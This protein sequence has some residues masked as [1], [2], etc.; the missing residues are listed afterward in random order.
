MAPP[1]TCRYLEERTRWRTFPEVGEKVCLSGGSFDEGD[2]GEGDFGLEVVVVVAE[3]DRGGA[4]LLVSLVT[5][6][7][8]LASF[9]TGGFSSCFLRSAGFRLTLA[10]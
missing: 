8:F 2:F 5:K 9:D 3:G 6:T 1:S 10:T 7:C 4:P